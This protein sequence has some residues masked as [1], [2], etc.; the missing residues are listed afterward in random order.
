MSGFEIAGIILGAYPVIMTVL[1]AYKET[2]T[3]RGARR[4]AQNLETERAI[5]GD[6]VYHLLA[7]N[8]SEADLV[9][10]TDQTSP[11]L[12]LWKDMALQMKLESRL[13]DEKSR[14]VVGTLQETKELL[15]LLQV[16]LTPSTHK[17][18]GTL[19]GNI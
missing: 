15:S 16:E 10:L 13:G 9:R 6:F 3:G 7:P 8:V 2:R 4:L 5:F 12:E 18:V 1:A 14:I 11:D 19:L 17:L